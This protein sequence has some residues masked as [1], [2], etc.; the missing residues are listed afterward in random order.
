MK[1]CHVI[2]STSEAKFYLCFAP[3][4]AVG[5]G[6]AAVEISQATAMRIY[7]LNV[8]MYVYSELPPEFLQ[9]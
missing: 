2:Y 7:S 9:Q 8:S 4:D 5:C 1:D 3:I 6:L